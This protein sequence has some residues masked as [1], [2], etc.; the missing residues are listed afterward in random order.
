MR[1]LPLLFCMILCMGMIHA[2][3]YLGGS[4]EPAVRFS[5]GGSQAVED[6][7][8][9]SFYLSSYADT[10]EL[11][12]RLSVTEQAGETELSVD[13]LSLLWYLSEAVTVRLGR[14]AT[15][16]GSSFFF[17]P[18]EFL[19]TQDLS[20]LLF[21]QGSTSIVPETL[22]ELSYLTD[23]VALSLSVAPVYRFAPTV[24]TDD[25][26][27]PLS[28][29]PQTIE[30]GVGIVKQ[31]GKIEYAEPS[32]PISISDLRGQLSLSFQSQGADL[33]L[34]GFYGIDPNP[35]FQVLNH[36]SQ[37]EIYTVE[38]IPQLAHT[39][40]LGVSLSTSFERGTLY[41]DSA[42][43]FAKVVGTPY[44]HLTGSILSLDASQ[45]MSDADEFS[46]SIGTQLF[47]QELS[48]YLICE[49]A[50]KHYL[51]AE[52][53]KE[54]LLSQTLSLLSTIDL[55]DYSL[56]ATLLAIFSLT[57]GSLFASPSLTYL[58]SQEFSLTA[59]LLVPVGEP[60]SEFG[61]FDSLTG[62]RVA[63]TYNF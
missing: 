6:R 32:R 9:L 38:L 62:L 18:V 60:D 44:I 27:F 55:L 5:P 1:R 13:E 52:E 42:I 48:G 11:S 28:D 47:Y 57:D 50:S 14:Y 19:H 25:E 51:T 36:L 41:A 49:L 17:S 26:I 37:P 29:F 21:S 43:R 23:S 15:H 30:T 3:T 34:Y 8:R 20:G 4:Y 53:I 33:S 22:L 35:A 39:A 2:E 31:L 54:P 40:A 16:N 46:Y 56:Q 24:A 7:H 58:G 10:L 63:A 59:S 12:S 45:Q 61:Q